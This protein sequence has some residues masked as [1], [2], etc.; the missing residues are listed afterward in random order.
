ML[1]SGDSEMDKRNTIKW[2]YASVAKEGNADLAH[3][4]VQVL[5]NS[6]VLDALR[7]VMPMLGKGADNE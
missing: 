2:A 6:K 1:L 4:F 5:K 3:L 7:Q